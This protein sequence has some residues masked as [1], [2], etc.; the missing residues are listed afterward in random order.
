[1]ADASGKTTFS[2]RLLFGSPEDHRMAERIKQRDQM[3]MADLYD[4]YGALI[5][6]VIVRSVGNQE[7]AED[8]VQETFLLVWNRIHTFDLERGRLGGWLV[9]IARNRAIDYLR[10]TNHK[11]IA[12]TDRLGEFEHLGVPLDRN[13]EADWLIQREWA[14]RALALLNAD[15]HKVLELTYFEGLTQTEIAEALEKPLGTVKSLVRSALKAIRL[16]HAC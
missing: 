12:A 15:Q 2:N 10:S 4:K 7:T 13:S 5:Y 8:L 1:M 11:Q 3:A 16:Q 6:S 9:T 14:Q